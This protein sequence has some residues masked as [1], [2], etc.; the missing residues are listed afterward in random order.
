MDAPLPTA[1]GLVIEGASGTTS[2]IAGARAPF[3][4]GN[5]SLRVDRDGDVEEISGGDEDGSLDV[6]E[7]A[8]EKL[9]MGRWLAVGGGEVITG[10]RG[11][12]GRGGRCPQGV[13]VFRHGLNSAPAC[14][15]SVGD[16]PVDFNTANRHRDRE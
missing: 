8:V 1:A 7:E 6:V 11:L 4:L 14:R 9:L 12:V 5:A 3:P 13:T 15:D 10:I 2:A 16:A